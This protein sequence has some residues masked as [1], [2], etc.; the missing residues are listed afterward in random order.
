M[1]SNTSKYINK[2]IISLKIEEGPSLGASII[3]AVS[4]N[5]FD[6]FES[7]VKVIVKEKECYYPNEE[8]VQEY[9]EIYS[10]YRRVY[11]NIKNI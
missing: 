7:A 4:L 1:A 9:K 11:E 10:R 3:A 2:K 5:W 6:S 8:A